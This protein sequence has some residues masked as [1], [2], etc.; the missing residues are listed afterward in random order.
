MKRM[1]SSVGPY[2]LDSHIAGLDGLSELSK[3]EYV[4]LP[5]FFPDERIYQA[6]DINFLNF[7]WNLLIGV[8]N[9]RG[10]EAEQAFAATFAHLFS[11]MGE[12]AERVGSGVIWRMPEG[13]VILEQERQG[14]AHCVQFFLTSGL[15]IRG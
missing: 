10:G 11:L 9:S 1:I 14:D 5:K 7:R 12:P 3:E 4:A 15:P 6:P 8:T 13:N 2:T